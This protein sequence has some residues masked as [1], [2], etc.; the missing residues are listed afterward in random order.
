MPA[1]VAGIHVLN[2]ENSKTW[3]AGTSPAKT[4]EPA[5]VRPGIATLEGKIVRVGH[6]PPLGRSRVE[7]LIGEL[8]PLAI[9]HRFLFRVEPQ[10]QLLPHV[11]GRRPP[12]QWLDPTRR[13]RL[14]IEHPAFGVAKA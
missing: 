3:M 2:C 6:C 7:H 9:G 5:L 13:L 8:M 4:M 12:H 14:K 11:A 1:P 10:P